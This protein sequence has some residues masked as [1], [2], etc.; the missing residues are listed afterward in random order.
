MPDAADDSATVIVQFVVGS[1]DRHGTE[2]TV[3]PCARDMREAPEAGQGKRV[4]LPIPSPGSRQPLTC[5]QPDRQQRQHRQRAELLV[6]PGRVIHTKR[7][8]IIT[9]TDARATANAVHSPAAPC[10]SRNASSHPSGTPISQ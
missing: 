2:W 8:A 5:E 7:V 9:A 6:L 10:P 3:A 4:V 1:V